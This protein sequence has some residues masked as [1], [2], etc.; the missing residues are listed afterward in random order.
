MSMSAGFWVQDSKSMR[1]TAVWMEAPAAFTLEHV[2]DWK[3]DWTVAF[4]MIAA[5]RQHLW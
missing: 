4:L 3:C 2:R 1:D 5:T